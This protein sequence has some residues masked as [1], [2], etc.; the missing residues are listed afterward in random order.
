MLGSSFPHLDKIVRSLS[1]FPFHPIL[2][3]ILIWLSPYATNA[4]EVPF[5]QV[6]TAAAVITAMAVIVLILAW[7]LTGRRNAA[8]LSVFLLILG[9][10]FYGKVFDV[11]NMWLLSQL[12]VL[13]FMLAWSALFL[14]AIVHVLRKK[15]D[16]A[17]LTKILNVALLVMLVMPTLTSID[18]IHGRKKAGAVSRPSLDVARA[19]A[20]V[21]AAGHP[22]IYYLIFDRYADNRTLRAKY[23]YDNR[24]F[25]DALRRRGFYVADRSRANYTKTA[26][27]LA[28]SM[29]LMHLESLAQ[30][31]GPDSNDWHPYYSFMKDNLVARFLKSLGVRYVHMGSWW[32]PT[33]TNVLADEN[34]NAF[35]GMAGL[36]ISFNEFEWLIVESMLPM[37]LAAL[38]TGVPYEFSRR[39]FLRIK[40]KFAKIGK[41]KRKETPLF[42][43]AHMLIPHDPHV[44]YRDGRFKP[45][46][47]AAKR[48]WSE[49]Y[50]DQLVYA[51]TEIE[52]LVDRLLAKRPQPIIIIQADEGPFPERYLRDEQ[53][54]DW[55]AATT[56]ELRQK[57]R[58]LNAYY[59]P[60]GNYK[61][62][63]PDI[64]PV[65]T[66]RV[67]FNR[68]FGQDLPLLPDNSYT[69]RSEADLYNLSD[70]TNTVR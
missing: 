9:L 1:T 63:R 6:A 5:E 2:L 62:L 41:I 33:R 57:F 29:N 38:I 15:D 19:K 52:K 20:A 4:Q 66:F 14:V 37:R 23:G 26:Q 64:T 53:D 24:P 13:P 59:F 30:R 3:A 10:F 12:P 16:S 17:N 68:Y 58:I 27:S 47:E 46:A 40:R 28:S 51:N 11:A 7:R 56:E 61:E 22:D 18:T 43:F 55:H 32:E 50:L 25:L 45:T 70:V 42:I 31:I 60:D 21:R 39:Q 54:F 65:N 34:F 36:D 69:H 67:V 44:F 48:R 49:N 8:G 35:Q